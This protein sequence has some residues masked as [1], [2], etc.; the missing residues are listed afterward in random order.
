MS[1]PRRES[2]GGT[3]NI[4]YGLVPFKC[5][6]SPATEPARAVPKLL[7]WRTWVESTRIINVVVVHL[8][9]THT[10]THTHCV[11]TATRRL[12]LLQGVTSHQKKKKN[13][14]WMN[15]GNHHMVWALGISLVPN[16]D[17]T[18]CRMMNLRGHRRI[19]RTEE[20]LC[21]TKTFFFP[22]S[23]FLTEYYYPSL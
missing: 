15:D 9:V 23:C 16:L 13:R 8:Q 11:W 14:K 18:G 20:H 7:R 12:S 5:A 6:T 1:P 17:P 22:P 4:N 3:N 10:H 21:H 2:T 19:T